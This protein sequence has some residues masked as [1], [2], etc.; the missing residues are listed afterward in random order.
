MRKELCLSIFKAADPPG[1]TESR[2]YGASY[3]EDDIF[4]R[5]QTDLQ[6]HDGRITAFKSTNWASSGQQGITDRQDYEKGLMMFKNGQW[7]PLATGLILQKTGCH[8]G[9]V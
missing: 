4:F 3:V 7:M 8:Q 2:M 9:R 1:E 6:W 5:Q